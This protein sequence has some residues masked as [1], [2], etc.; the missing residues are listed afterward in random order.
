VFLVTKPA[1]QLKSDPVGIATDRVGVVQASHSLER[2]ARHRA[3]D[4]VAAEDDRVRLLSLYLLERGI[5]PATMSPPKT[6][7]SGCSRATSS[8]TA[9]SAGRLPW[10]S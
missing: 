5:G 1:A 7:A 10:T 9:S 8:S 2:L 6:I 3:R 4:D